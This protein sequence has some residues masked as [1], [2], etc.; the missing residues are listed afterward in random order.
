MSDVTFRRPFK[1]ESRETAVRQWNEKL[2]YYEYVPGPVF[3]I[4]DD[5]GRLVVGFE[6]ETQAS[7][8]VKFLNQLSPANAQTCAETIS[9]TVS[10]CEVVGKS[11]EISFKPLTPLQ[12]GA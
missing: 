1:Y 8:W 10:A 12:D 5:N 3:D 7:F 11:T 4:S 9:T 6:S 2:G